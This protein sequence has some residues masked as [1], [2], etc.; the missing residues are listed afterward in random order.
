MSCKKC[1]HCEFNLNFDNTYCLNCGEPKDSKRVLE[2]KKITKFKVSGLNFTITLLGWLTASCVLLLFY[3]I[4]KSRSLVGIYLLSG[5]FVIFLLVIA[6]AM[7]V[8]PR[9][10]NY[11]KLKQRVL[12]KTNPN[13]FISK[14]KIIKRR[15]KELELQRQEI[16]RV[17]Q[18]AKLG[19]RK[20]WV[21]L[22][23]A[24]EDA[25]STI[26]LQ[27]AKYYLKEIEISLF[28]L[29]NKLLPFIYEINDEN[30]IVT[31]Y[32]TESIK[33]AR[34]TADDISQR[35]V[36][37]AVDLDITEIRKVMSRQSEIQKSVDVLLDYFL[38]KEAVSTLRKVKLNEADTNSEIFLEDAV[39]QFDI[40]NFQVEVTDFYSSLQELEHQFLKI[41]ALNQNVLSLES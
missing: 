26:K 6:G 10:D 16:E 12:P 29:Q 4:S 27:K 15:I 22:S 32:Q 40:F 8:K 33:R 38:Y 30:L 18:N 2:S 34:Q 39:R 11:R 3:S 25:L 17:L 31:D 1:S 9:L 36:E 35:L 14:K 13:N 28:K 21:I 20:K 19:N 23:D 7:F 24:L 41:Q 5:S 37:L